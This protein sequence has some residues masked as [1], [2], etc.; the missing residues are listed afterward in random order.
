MRKQRWMTLGFYAA[1]GSVSL[2]L[3][4]YWTF[5]T[6]ALSQRIAHE[7][8][9]RTRG[10]W[11]VDMEQLDTYWFSG[12][13]AQNVTLKR[14]IPI[15]APWSM[16]FESLHARLRLSPLLLGRTSFDFGMPWGPGRVAL[17]LSPRK[18]V[19]SEAPWPPGALWGWLDAVDLSNPNMLGHWAGIPISGT[20]EGDYNL[21]SDGSI[22][23]SEGAANFNL[24]N[25]NI[26]PGTLSGF[27]LPQVDLGSLQM[28]WELRD[29]RIKLV[30]FRQDGGNIALKVQASI[31]ANSSIENSRID[32]CIQFRADPGF[33]NANPKIRSVLQLAEVQLKKDSEGFLHLPLS[34]PL[35]APTMRPG[36]CRRG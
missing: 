29:G 4:L 34:G 8:A 22:R 1:V 36:L 27:T 35:N 9:V 2:L 6:D 32:V 13:V 23:K 5:P 20:L 21:S 3:S 11:H 31:E 14:Q 25:I 15:D 12:V 30:D 16:H 24:G 10:A 26:G 18:P 17:R 33:L 19:S 7:L 28:N